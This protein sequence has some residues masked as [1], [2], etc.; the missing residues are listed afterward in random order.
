M[1]TQSERGIALVLA[2]FLM[3][4][5]SVLGASLMFLSQTETYASM[6]YR[7]MSQARYA[8]E[9]G[10]QRAANFLLAPD[11]AD[12]TKYL[13]P[14]DTGADPWTNYNISVSPVTRVS[15]GQPVV[16][17]AKDATCTGSNYP[18]AAVQ[19]AFCNAAKGTLT[20]GNASILYN[21][22]A[23]LIAMQS[24]VS[25]SSVPV[26]VQTW[27]ITG[28]GS[29]SGSRTATV[30][31]A[32]TIETPKMPAYG[33]AAFATNPG[34]GAL[35]F[36]GTAGTDS[37]DPTGLTGSTAPTLTGDGGDVGTNGNLQIA[38]TVTVQGNLV[39]PRTGVGAC[40]QGNVTALTETVHATVQDS[41]IKLPTA[42]VYPTPTIPAYSGLLGVTNALLPGTT[43]TTC[44]LLG[45]TLT[46]GTVA[47]VLAGTKQC[48][49]TA[50]G[51]G[52]SQVTL[53]NTT[54]SPLSLPSI[55]PNG[56]V[57]FVLVAGGPDPVQYNFNSISLGGGASIGVS[58]TSPTQKVVV[59]IVGKDSS[60][61][62][63][64]NPLDL[65][66]GTFAGVTGT[67]ATTVS[68]CATCSDFDASVLQFVY[69][70]TGSVDLGGNSGAAAAFYMPN[71]SVTLHGNVDLYGSVVANT[72]NDVGNA[73]LYYD[74]KLAGS[75]FV[76]GNPVIGTFTWKGY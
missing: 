56:H 30:E 14:S 32:A 31:V 6:N 2:L 39:T 36:Q 62:A 13:L 66:G 61:T 58:A 68:A 9:A 63:I 64:A 22:T 76:P 15:N 72:F 24:F 55:S 74:S 40:T 75:L 38:G 5:M 46:Q 70:G 23:T 29:L 27:Q 41:E 51:G 73:S 10:I 16:L 4:A 7:M 1:Q 8:G 20:A 26:V 53:N 45:P 33:Y 65:S 50:L 44:A 21:A 71:A 57:N 35:Q 52:A 37:Y 69:G 59:D 11:P 17:S 28:D 49:V 48:S 3:A 25:Y 54:G 19:T 60:G 47:E 67:G 43:L 18:V 34:C 42:I 12:P